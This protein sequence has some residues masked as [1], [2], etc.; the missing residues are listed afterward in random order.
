[1]PTWFAL[2]D[3]LVATL[4][5]D[6]VFSSTIPS[7]LQ[8]YLACGRPIVA[9]MDGEGAR[10]IDESR[11][12]ATAPAGDIKALAAAVRRIYDAEPRRALGTMGP[13]ARDYYLQNFDRDEVIGSIEEI[14]VNEASKRNGKVTT[15][16]ALCLVATECLDTQ[17]LGLC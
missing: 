13:H 15:L 14:L 10:V 2:A 5:P 3:L 11:A 16:K 8:S 9:G 7:K 6:P 1:M 4:K 17:W 12:G